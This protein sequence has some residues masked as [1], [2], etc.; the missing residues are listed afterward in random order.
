MSYAMEKI[1]NIALLGHGGN[2][3]TT[4]AE[5]ILSI[6]GMTDRMAIDTFSELF[7]PLSWEVEG[8]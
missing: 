6:T 5:S 2:G 3:K 4:L 1:R 8:Y 7:I